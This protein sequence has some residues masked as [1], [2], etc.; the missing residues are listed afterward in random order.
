MQ[1]YYSLAV[2][3]V[4][5]L[6][7]PQVVAAGFSTYA[8]NIPANDYLVVKQL[9]NSAPQ[10][11]TPPDGTTL[12]KWN[13]AGQMFDLYT[14]TSGFGWDPQEPVVAVG[15]GVVVHSP[16]PTVLVFT[17]AVVTPILPVNLQPGLNLL[18]AQMP[19]KAVPSE[20]LGTLDQGTIVYRLR[21][22]GDA[23]SINFANYDIDYYRDGMWFDSPVP[24]LN[25]G[26]AAFFTVASP[27][28]ITAQPVSVTNATLG[29]SASF[30][31][32]VTG[33]PPFRYQWRLN[34]QNIP[35]ATNATY[36]ITNVVAGDG[37]LYNVSVWNMVGATQS[38]NAVLKPSVAGFTLS[39]S[40]AGAG[41]LEDF[42]RLLSG[43]NRNATLEPGEPLH[44]GK[45]AGAS[46]WLTWKAPATGIATMTVSGSSFDTVLAAYIG[47][48]LSNLVLVDFSDDDAGW[49]C[50]R[51]R[52]NARVD[53]DY[54]ICVA[55]LGEGQGD[56]LLGWNLEETSE[57]LPDIGTQPQ[58][59][60]ASPGDL[61]QFAV[62]VTNAGPFT[63][64]WFRDGV[65]LT[66]GFGTSP[67]LSLSNI[68]D[69]AV[70]TYVVRI[71]KGNRQR[72][73]RAVSLQVE[74]P[75]PGAPFSGARATAKLFD[76]LPDG[77]SGTPLK[78][79]SP[80]F[81]T[82]NHGFSGSQTVSTLGAGKDIGEPNHCNETG[83]NSIWYVV[84]ADNNGT[85]YVNTDGSSFDTVLAAYSGPPP[86]SLVSYGQLVS[87]ACDNNSGLDG[88]DSRTSFAAVSN[89]VYYLAVDGVGGATG[90][91]KIAFKLVRPLI[92]TNM[93]Y[94]NISGGRYTM[95]VNSTPNLTTTIQ[96]ATNVAGPT[97]INLTNYSNAL[98]I[99]NFTNNGA[100]PGTNRFYRGLNSF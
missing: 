20:I 100:G 45:R 87:L 8:V 91:A 56:I 78:A 2:A 58:D 97:W 48:N 90:S 95:K 69:A 13:G 22:G 5:S 70:G 71:T 66:N 59:V 83:G 60:T 50:G 75:Q 53:V 77:G 9:S 74:Q 85:L 67:T 21:P 93:V 4:F 76:V 80:K 81:G 19:K 37:G 88:L 35:G 86:A 39:D 73:S 18:G 92:L 46:V 52:F 7:A 3:A 26:Q 99:F 55:G 49:G 54:R 25:V 63:F 72:F 65:A 43:H 14:Y 47:N 31:V 41:L 29:Q 32:T 16:I 79:P 61:V 15:E 24:M 27:V 44:G 82:V 96:Y 84:Q 64:Q 57:I 36:S 38:S 17:G 51:I 6:L 34:G 62:A 68:T 30:S 94:T 1:R 33:A 23:S 28:T 40:F 89:T 42:A 10:F 98:G 11:P 12:A